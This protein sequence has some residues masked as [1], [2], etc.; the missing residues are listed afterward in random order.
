MRTI[1]LRSK[2]RNDAGH[3]ASDKIDL[4]KLST[5]DCRDSVRLAIV[6]ARSPNGRR[7][8][9][10]ESPVSRRPFRFLDSAMLSQI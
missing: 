5:L 7:A 10:A 1:L 8:L 4:K 3:V 9:A 2:E 6:F